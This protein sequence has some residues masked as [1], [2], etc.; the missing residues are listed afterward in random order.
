VA[1][2]IKRH[3][4]TARRAAR[5]AR[6]APAPAA[7]A[8]AQPSPISC[9]RRAGNTCQT[10]V[11]RACCSC[12][13]WCSI[14]FLYLGRLLSFPSAQFIAVTAII[15]T[16]PFR[17]SLPLFIIAP[18]ISSSFLS[19]I[20]FLLLLPFKRQCDRSVFVL[21]AA[22]WGPACLHMLRE[23]ALGCVR[24]QESESRR[25]LLALVMWLSLFAATAVIASVL[26]S[27][28]NRR[29]ITVLH[30]LCLIIS[31][32]VDLALLLVFLACTATSSSPP[33]PLPVLSS[34]AFSLLI[35]AFF[36]HSTQYVIHLFF[37]ILP[38][39]AFLLLAIATLVGFFNPLFWL[40]LA[41]H[42][43]YVI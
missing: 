29:A 12:W 42:T 1:S 2:R 32:L 36:L 39:C 27:H 16:A 19:F 11:S 13:Y 37:Y 10:A 38:C 4:T 17:P 40:D 22:P 30:V 21:P 3:A 8:P 31:I 25:Y 41:Y 9:L 6:V 23:L 5:A 24:I 26:T 28:T 14:A 18:I 7:A 34:P 35:I 15:I 33:L 20:A 43:Y